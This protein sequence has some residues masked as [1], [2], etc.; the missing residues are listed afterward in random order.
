[1]A[2]RSSKLLILSSRTFKGKQLSQSFPLSLGLASQSLKKFRV[3][4]LPELWEEHEQWGK[5]GTLPFYLGATTRA[6]LGRLL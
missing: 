1:M 2:I 3:I 6:A 4:A 5:K